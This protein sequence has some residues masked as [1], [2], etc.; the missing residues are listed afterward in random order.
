VSKYRKKEG[1]KYFLKK[2]NSETNRLE[3][4]EIDMRS[5]STVDKIDKKLNS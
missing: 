5:H 1:D 2:L 4:V 3:W